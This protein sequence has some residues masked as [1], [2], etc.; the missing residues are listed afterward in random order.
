M[1]LFEECGIPIRAIEQY[2]DNEAVVTT[3]NQEHILKGG[4]TKF[5][6][7][8]LFQLFHEVKQGIIKSMWISTDENEAD[9]GTKN[10]KGSKYKKFAQRT[11]S[12]LEVVDDFETDD[13]VETDDEL[14]KV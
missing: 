10:L 8:N 1:Q 12:R 2:C 5:M 14:N 11:F 9:I 6:N 4:S 13:E 3:N 7:R